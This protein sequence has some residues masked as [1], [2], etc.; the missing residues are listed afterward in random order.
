MPVI[1]AWRNLVSCGGGSVAACSSIGT[2]HS[3]GYSS[4]SAERSNSR[5][6]NVST[7]PLGWAGQ[8]AWACAKR[9][10]GHW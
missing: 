9:K 2:T 7:V 10:E 1:H 8:D 5:F 6:R 3:L 4:H